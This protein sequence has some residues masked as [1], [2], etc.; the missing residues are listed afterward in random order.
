MV[1]ASVSTASG[2]AVARIRTVR[3]VVNPLSG[4]VDA[5]AAEAL[6]AILAERWSDVKVAEVQPQEI[7]PELRAAVDAAP[8][9]LIL[10]AGDG[11]IRM[12]ATLAGA[13]GPLLAPL[14]GGT[15][16][17]LPHAIYGAVAWRPALAQALETGVERDISGGEVDGRRF[18]VAA[19]LGAPALWAPAREAMRHG[20][21][22][23]AYLRAQ[24]ALNRAFS[25]HLRF[26]LDGGP[27]QK[28]EALT[29]M[30]PLVSRALERADVLEA[31]ALDPK[32][33]SEG[34]RLGA[35]ALLADILG[36][37]RT[38]PAVRVETCKTGRAWSRAQIPAVLD[39][40]PHRLHHDASIAFIPRA[41]RALALRQEE[42]TPEAEHQRRK[43]Q[44]RA[45]TAVAASGAAGSEP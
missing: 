9:L 8:D 23:L 36:D 13:D 17:M 7:E 22:R 37:W 34:V 15:M 30:C 24:R 20:N 11:T 25:G 29:L 27:R 35:R 28:A 10:L 41:F 6:R 12:A 33:A 1:M 32:G 18:F 26:S 14:P 42:P 39:G 31:L 44:A 38:D 16:N 19:I 45:A 2:D 4:S 3:A 21:L 5:G 43:S 40:E